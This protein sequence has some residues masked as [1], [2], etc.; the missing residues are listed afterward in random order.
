M[1]SAMGFL[2]AMGMSAIANAFVQMFK[3]I[4]DSASQAEQAFIKLSIAEKSISQLGVDITPQELTDIIEKVSAA[5]LAVSKIDAQK[6]VSSLAVLTKDLKLSAKE[7]EKLAMAIPLVA[8]QAGVSI[9]SATDQVITGL[10]KSGRGWADLGITVDAELS[11]K[12]L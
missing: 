5:Y 11:N 8:Q 2:V 12:K 6:M 9:D 10:T 4:I 3:K 7:Y 1:R